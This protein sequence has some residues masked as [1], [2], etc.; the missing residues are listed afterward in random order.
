MSTPSVTSLPDASRVE[1]RM[2]HAPVE[3]GLGMVPAP[4]EGFRLRAPLHDGVRDD[5]GL[6]AP[7]L[8][9]LL[10][11][12]GIGFLI[13]T[14]GELTAGAPTVEL[15]IDHL[16]PSAADATEVRAEF[17]LLHIDE[18]VGVGRADIRDDT[19]RPVAHAVATMALTGVPDRPGALGG[20]SAPDDAEDFRAGRPAFDAARL[21]PA[22]LEFD[23]DLAVLVPGRSATNL[24]GTTHGAVLAALAKAAQIRFLARDG[25]G[26]RSLSDT[27]DYLRPVST[28]TRVRAR[29]ETVRSG[30]RFWTV[31]TELLLPD[32]RV[33]VRATG[34]GIR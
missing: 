24:N 11:D 32:D 6:V 27:V 10:A 31:R 2:R 3:R 12:S 23:G 19:G 21:D 4:G 26:A 22:T 28:D 16:G 15:R 29:C 18:Q 13:Y 1:Q 14:A 7:A 33:A 5:D 30:R 8:V 9:A 34:N 17:T 20:D 25:A